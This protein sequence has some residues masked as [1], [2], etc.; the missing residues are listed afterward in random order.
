MKRLVFLIA[1]AALFAAFQIVINCSSPLDSPDG[2]NPQPPR[3][4]TV[5][6]TD[7]VFVFDSTIVIDTIFGVDTIFVVDTVGIVDTIIL[8]DTVIVVD[9]IDFHPVVICSKL[10]SHHHKIYWTFLD[11]AGQFHL[12]FEAF[13]ERSN[14]PIG[15][16]IYI[17]GQNYDWDLAQ[18]T[19]L[20]LDL[21][22]E[23]R[24]TIRI[25]SRCESDNNHH[26]D[27]D[28]NHNSDNH[29]DHHDDDDDHDH[30]GCS[31]KNVEVCL[32]LT[33]Q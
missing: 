25:M 16:T 9:S 4:D 10:G 17:N 29:N 15:L 14:S 13:I 31:Y 21:V 24:S 19:V 11:V 33:R 18:N 30:N 1:A 3:V 20:E 27:D 5:L 12:E 28:D 7:T 32:T 2:I 23:E 6:I 22:L 8:I 26:D